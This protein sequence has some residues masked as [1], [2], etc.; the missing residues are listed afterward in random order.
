MCF[1]ELGFGSSTSHDWMVSELVLAY[2]IIE[3]EHEIIVQL[4]KEADK[5][6]LDVALER[7][8]RIP[9]GSQASLPG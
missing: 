6:Q 4:I 9:T 7:E 2:D 5:S 3:L 8:I 1:V